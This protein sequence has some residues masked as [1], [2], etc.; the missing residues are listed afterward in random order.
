MYESR[1][2]KYITNL[3]FLQIRLAHAETAED[4]GVVLAKPAGDSANTYPVVVAFGGSVR[5]Q[6]FSS[7]KLPGG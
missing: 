5:K 6:D 7:C 4:L 1:Y 3:Q 2:S